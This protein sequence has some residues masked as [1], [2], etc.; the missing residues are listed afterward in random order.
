MTLLIIYKGLRLPVLVLAIGYITY[1]V[2]KKRKKEEVE[3][4]KYRMLEE[5]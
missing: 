2:Y 4:P 5:D 1:H 3:R